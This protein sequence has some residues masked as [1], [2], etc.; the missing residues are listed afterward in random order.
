MNHAMAFIQQVGGVTSAWLVTQKHIQEGWPTCE[1]TLFLT[2]F[3]TLFYF[4]MKH[5]NFKSSCSGSDF[6]LRFF[7]LEEKF[8]TNYLGNMA[9]WS[10]L[11][12]SL[13]GFFQFLQ[14]VKVKGIFRGAIC[15]TASSHYTKNRQYTI[16]SY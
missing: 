8:T 10:H 4:L 11:P 13:W 5:K 3:L 14:G 2:H 9:E 6:V 7:L 1:Q 15:C 12:P 16:N